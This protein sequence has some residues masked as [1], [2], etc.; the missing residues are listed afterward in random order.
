M[1]DLQWIAQVASERAVNS[2]PAGLVVAALAWLSLRAFR[3]QSSS[4]RFTVWFAALL[5][6]ASLPFAPSM[7]HGS[8]VQGS[9]AQVTL[10]PEWA[11]VIFIGWM[12]IATI[13]IIRLAMGVIQLRHLRKNCE[14]IALSDLPVN[15]QPMITQFQATRH[16][17]ICSAPDVR[18][19][20]AIGFLNPA[21]FLPKWAINDLPAEDLKA[22]LLH[23]FAHLRRG[24]DWTNLAQKLLRTV[25]FFH[26]SVWWIE[27]RLALEREMA[28]DEQV[29]AETGN[30]RAYAECLV[31]LAE[32]SVVRRG[33]AMAQAAISHA[34]ET[35]LRLA[36]ILQAE[37]VAPRA[38]K[39]TLA[40]VA[41]IG[42][43][44]LAVLPGVPKLVAFQDPARTPVLSA[45]RAP[46]SPA[47]L[48]VGEQ[49][50][51]SVKP[52]APNK[53][54]MAHMVP[55]KSA[56]V[57][58]VKYSDARPR[59]AVL[60]AAARQSAPDRQLLVIVQ[61]SEYDG[62]SPAKLTFCVW[63]VTFTGQDRNTVRAEVI[64]KS[65]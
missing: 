61:S 30:R 38:F 10:S 37:P 40:A 44:A 2:I 28:C 51:N 29:L 42:L 31:S 64:A 11:Q 7:S 24:D 12:L 56:Q 15:L 39:P 27:R 59:A 16:V 5:A 49:M 35:S 13:A 17:T 62:V 8:V 1:M 20:T 22:V 58:A 43:V 3:G 23:E 57:I 33:L 6:I 48:N 55:K 34:R 54:V 25:F 53:V 19:P 4:V 41:A 21:I 18:V 60:R 36:R 52:A 50:S 47:K 32:K 26:P 14:V 45:T 46:I 65:L 63:R 9:Q